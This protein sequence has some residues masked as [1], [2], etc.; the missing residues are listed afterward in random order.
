MGEILTVTMQK[1]GVAKTTTAAALAQAAA[2]TGK[3]VLAIDLDPQG[4]LSF[5]LGANTNAG[6]TYNLLMDQASAEDV[7][8][9]TTQDLDVI[10][11]GR[12]L[13]AITGG[14]GTARRLQRAIEPI[15][16]RYNLIIIDTPT[17]PG[18]LSYNA[19]QA[20]TGLIIPMQ[21]DIFDL[22][23]FYQTIETA[24][25]FRESNPELTI[26]GIVITMFDSRSNISKQM[27]K[28]V[29]NKAAAQGVPYLGTV[30]RGVAIREAIAFQ[31]SLYS[32]APRSNPARDYME[33]FNYIANYSQ[34]DSLGDSRN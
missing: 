24:E 26:T 23:S 10:P 15:R 16:G 3:K 32:Y 4:Q 22:Q 12:E 1:G 2:F 25:M 7:I 11:A 29:I 19:I 14:K 21:A 5:A 31:E 6:N 18:E 20:A 9:H 8:Q 28:T 33:V 17:A 27:Q 13:Q 34:F 30:R